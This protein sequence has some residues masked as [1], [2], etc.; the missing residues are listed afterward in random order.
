M[1]LSSNQ[2]ELAI[3]IGKLR[4]ASG[5]GRGDYLSCDRAIS[6]SFD[7]QAA[8][9]ECAMALR[10]GFP[11][12]AY[13]PAGEH[14]GRGVVQ[15]PDVGPIEVKSVSKAHHKIILHSKPILMAP[16]VR[17]LVNGP[18]VTFTG[19]A[20]GFE[21]WDKKHWDESLPTPAYARKELYG[22][23]SFWNWCEGSGWKINPVDKP[24]FAEGWEPRPL[25]LSS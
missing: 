19:W 7:I 8:V 14:K 24:I 15:D 21:I 12:R 4:T 23:Q 20:F 6:G 18:E 16:H 11:W 3:R 2:L 10:T 1:M 22:I 25:D 13:K 9:A 17:L 5:S